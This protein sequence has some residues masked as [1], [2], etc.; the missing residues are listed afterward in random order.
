MIK[1]NLSSIFVKNINHAKI[2]KQQQLSLSL[3]ANICSSTTV[4][5]RTN[6]FLKRGFPWGPLRAV[7]CEAMLQ[8]QW[9]KPSA[10]MIFVL[11]RGLVG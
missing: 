7:N 11:T 9:D 5:Q 3:F 4:A 2:S 6:I 10:K 8:L 1:M